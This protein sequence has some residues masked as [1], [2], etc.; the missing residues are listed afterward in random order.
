MTS[1]IKL[2]S[3]DFLPKTKHI[4]VFRKLQNC[5]QAEKMEVREVRRRKACGA[6]NDFVG[7]LPSNPEAYELPGGLGQ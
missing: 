4:N 1:K 3:F 2:H 5:L 7:W 6:A